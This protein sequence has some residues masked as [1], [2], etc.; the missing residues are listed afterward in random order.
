MGV[1]QE[2]PQGQSTT[3]LTAAVLVVHDCLGFFEF[4]VFFAKPNIAEN[5]FV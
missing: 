5:I 2:R 1:R 3:M 4:K